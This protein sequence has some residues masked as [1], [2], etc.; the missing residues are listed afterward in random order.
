MIPGHV[1]RNCVLAYYIP[2]AARFQTS[3]SHLSIFLNISSE[4]PRVSA[5]GAVERLP[6]SSE[7]VYEI[8]WRMERPGVTSDEL[9]SGGRHRGAEPVTA[10]G[11]HDTAVSYV[12]DAKNALR[13]Y[14][15]RPMM[16]TAASSAS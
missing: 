9:R 5:G 16:I 6:G 1:L 8:T 11:I 3:I 12:G 13:G 7:G 10:E 15:F 4:L 14:V 2:I